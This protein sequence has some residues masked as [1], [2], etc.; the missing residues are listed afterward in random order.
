MYLNQV[1]C[2]FEETIYYALSLPNVRINLEIS[3]FHYLDML[4]FT[5]QEDKLLHLFNP[6]KLLHLFNPQSQVSLHDIQFL[7]L[8]FLCPSSILS[9]LLNFSYS[10]CDSSSLDGC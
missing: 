1:V 8:F 6:H 3:F 5:L 4:N 2:L 7:I 9:F 10:T